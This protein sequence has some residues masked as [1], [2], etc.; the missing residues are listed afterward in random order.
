MKRSS[1]ALLTAV[2]LGS[3]GIAQ[4]QLVV[5]DSEAGYVTA[6][7][8]FLQQPTSW[9]DNLDSQPASGYTGPSFSYA[10]L[11][12]DSAQLNQARIF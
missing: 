8:D 12:S 7:K 10:G 4:A 3:V 6:N 1:L 11:N 2:L 5:Y 9:K